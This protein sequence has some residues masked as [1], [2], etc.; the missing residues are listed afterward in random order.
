[1]AKTRNKSQAV[2]FEVI[3]EMLSTKKAYP[4]PQL[5]TACRNKLFDL[6]YKREESRVSE[7]TIKQDIMDMC[8]LYGEKA[9]PDFTHELET[10][11]RK[12]GTEKVSIILPKDNRL[13]VSKRKDKRQRELYPDI[14]NC[15]DVD[16]DYDFGYCYHDWAAENNFSI[17][18]SNVSASD[19]LYI[20]NLLKSV[21]I[22]KNSPLF[23]DESKRLEEIN[24]KI[25]RN[26]S[27]EDPYIYFDQEEFYGKERM[28]TI[29][30]YLEKK[31]DL[32]I[33]FET[34]SG[35]KSWLRVKP[36]FLKEWNNMWYLIGYSETDKKVRHLSVARIKEIRETPK[37]KTVVKN[38]GH[39]SYYDYVW[40]IEPQTTQKV[41]TIIFEIDTS[42]GIILQNKF[43]NTFRTEDTSNK[44][45]KRLSFK[46]VNNQELKNFLLS[47]GGDVQI[48]KPASLV[49]SIKKELQK[50]LQ[51]YD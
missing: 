41:M 7:R 13:I 30:E 25:T 10:K 39:G 14:E 33:R 1:M 42:K 28:D 34:L 6:G 50:A 8:V 3:D 4:W 47:L 51:Q 49:K 23:T 19:L 21:S 22:F 48:L 29:V 2:R 20:R 17:F 11:K 24:Q 26:I 16:V 31:K 9:H 35:K 32:E 15:T 45:R 40:G 37:I 12:D 38:N 46:A 36:F 18:D 44:K 43:N 5:A 27:N